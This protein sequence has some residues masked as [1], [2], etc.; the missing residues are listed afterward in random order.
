MAA[1]RFEGGHLVAGHR[2][3]LDISADGAWLATGSADGR[4]TIYAW[5]G[6]TVHKTLAAHVG[7]CLDTA[8]APRAA[9]HVGG[10]SLATCGADGHVAVWRD[11]V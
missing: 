8:F 10:E 3:L 9:G 1:Q 2:I 6:G 5:A 7:P 4:A 11:V